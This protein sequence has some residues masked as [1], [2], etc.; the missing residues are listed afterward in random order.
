MEIELLLKAFRFNVTKLMDLEDRLQL[1]AYELNGDNIG[2]PKIKSPEEAKYQTGTKIY[3]N[4]IPELML[5]ES[6]L[7]KERDYY[8]FAVKRVESFLQQLSDEEIKLIE[9]RYWHGFHIK[10]IA[11]MYY[12]SRASIY[13]EIDKILKS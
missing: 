5:Q 13:R 9:L 4:N 3:K 12:R 2:S 6:K 7:I 8:L 10:Y 1:L 11:K